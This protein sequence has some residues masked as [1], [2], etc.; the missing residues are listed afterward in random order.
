MVG[1]PISLQILTYVSSNSAICGFIMEEFFY[2]IDK[3]ENLHIVH[4]FTAVEE[5]IGN[6]TL[7]VTIMDDNFNA[8]DLAIDILHQPC[9]IP[10]GNYNAS[11]IFDTF[12]LFPVVSFV[13]Y[14]ACII[15]YVSLLYYRV[16]I[17]AKLLSLQTKERRLFVST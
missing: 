7:N 13:Q 11:G 6:E 5:S 1:V 3:Q 12:N 16:S 8:C 9:P 10:P 2:F 15:H 17:L 4:I 14:D